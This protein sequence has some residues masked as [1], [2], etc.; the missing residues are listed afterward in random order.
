LANTT[1]KEGIEKCGPGVDLSH[2]K[3][4]CIIENNQ[5]HVNNQTKYEETHFIALF[6]LDAIGSSFS[7]PTRAC[8]FALAR[9]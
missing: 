4:G 9:Y 7:R 1:H 8:G 3:S 6:S 5:Q 2:K